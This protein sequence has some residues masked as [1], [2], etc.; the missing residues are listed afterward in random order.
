MA[1]YHPYRNLRLPPNAPFELRPSPG[2]GWGAFAT[3]LIHRGEVILRENP[4]FVIPGPNVT[5]KSLWQAFLGLSQDQQQQFSYIRNNSS[6][7]FT[8]MI[9][10]MSQNHFTVVDDNPVTAQL[11][12]LGF[13]VLQSRF[14]HSCL[15]NS[16]TPAAPTYTVTRY[17]TRPIFAGDEI[18]FSYTPDLKF[19]VRQERHRALRFVC[20]CSACQVST[21][22]RI[23]IPHQTVSDQRRVLIRGLQYLVSGQDPVL[24]RRHGPVEDMAVPP[25]FFDLAKK[26]EAE[27]LRIPLSAKFIAVLLYA[28]LLEE[29]D[30]L[31]DHML[32]IMRPNSL[33]IAH[34]FRTRSNIAIVRHVWAQSTWAIRFWYALFYLWNKTDAA[35]P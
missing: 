32:N 24:K 13:F 20:T 2:K 14:N 4:L 26:R 9:Q 16:T 30:I 27:S 31:D 23:G 8:D 25:L 11:H 18:T 17:A 33:R 22:N 34:R 10:A 1:G 7:L 15:P 12:L 28:A 5:D 21:P 19:M 6:T 35:D 29:E 3:R